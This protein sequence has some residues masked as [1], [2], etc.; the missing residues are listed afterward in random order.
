MNEYTLQAISS[1]KIVWVAFAS[2]LYGAG[3]ISN[4][5]LRRFLMPLWMGLGIWVFGIWTGSFSPWSLLYVPLCC[6][7]LHLGY[8]GNDGK[9]TTKIR[10]RASYGLCLGIAALP[11]CIISH[12]WILFAFHV[13]LCVSASVLLGT[14]NPTRNARAEETLIAVLSTV[15]VLFLQ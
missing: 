6:A 13:G 1:L 10:K 15:L 7:S 3:G 12:L 2:L 4:K 5:W 14:I 9:I 8:S 11:I